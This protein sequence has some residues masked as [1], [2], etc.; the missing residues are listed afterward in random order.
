M[1]GVDDAPDIRGLLGALL[2]NHGFTFFG[3]GSGAECLQLVTR[4]APRL[5]LLDIDMPDM[6]GFETCGRL[7]ALEEMRPVPIAFVTARKT[8]DDMRSGLQ[9]GGNDFILKPFDG[10]RLLERVQHW[11]SRRVA[12]AG[13]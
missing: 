11:T 2:S 7:R 8:R 3:V 5:I 1:I 10:A 13:Y 12:G 4:V 6:N 9:V